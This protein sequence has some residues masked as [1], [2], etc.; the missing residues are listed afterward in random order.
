MVQDHF[1]FLYSIVYLAWAEERQQVKAKL[2]RI[3]PLSLLMLTKE[4]LFLYHELL[5]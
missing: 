5:C 2:S 3:Y 4:H 1:V